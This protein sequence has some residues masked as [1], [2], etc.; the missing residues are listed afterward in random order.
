LSAVE[1]AEA[2]FAEDSWADAEPRLTADD[3]RD[4]M[5]RNV[6]LFRRAET[7][8]EAVD[9]LEGPSHAI[10]GRIR[11]GVRLSADEWKVANLTT[12]A[13]LIARAALRRQ[14]SRGAHYRDDYPERD[15]IHWKKRRADRDALVAARTRTANRG[16]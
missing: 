3:V 4:L 9:R 7:L 13:W 8:R 11:R 16:A 5:W 1:L 10:T 15:D 14:E 2:S 12:V 6:G